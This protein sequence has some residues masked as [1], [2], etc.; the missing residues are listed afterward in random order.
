[1][2]GFLPTG[3]I[4]F[5]CT[6]SARDDGQHRARAEE[7]RQ[8]GEHRRAD[9]VEQCGAWPYERRR[10]GQI[11]VCPTCGAERAIDNARRALAAV[12]R[13]DAPVF[14]TLTLPSRG[15][16][17]L[18]EAMDEFGRALAVMRRR[19]A[20]RRAVRGGVCG[21]EPRLELRG[22]L[23]TLHAHA[24]LDADAGAFEVEPLREMWAALTDDRGALLVP[25]AGVELVSPADASR[26]V[27]KSQDWCPAPRALP[28]KALEVLGRANHRR[29]VLLLWGSARRGDG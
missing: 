3:P 10:C 28:P 2:T 21:V 20:F 12:D 24:I 29:H 19:A 5:S 15:P 27:T 23:W 7:L 11:K 16:W 4:G 25:D 6:R 8:I 22:A 18:R 13:F 1:M 14:V 9:R 26:Y 17:R